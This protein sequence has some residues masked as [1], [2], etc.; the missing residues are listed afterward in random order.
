MRRIARLVII[1]VFIILGVVTRAF[2]HAVPDHADPA[3]GSTVNSSPSMV[4]IW[5]DSDLEGEFSGIRVDNSESERVDK[6]DGRVDKSDAK[7]LEIDLLPLPAGVYTVFWTAVSRD[8]H[9][10]EGNYTFTVK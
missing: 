6:G 1:S 10:T 4:R 2:G 9:R 8:G 3:V 7:L 5:F